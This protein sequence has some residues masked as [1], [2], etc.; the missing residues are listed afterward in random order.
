M[1]QTCDWDGQWKA[2]QRRC[3]HQ[4]SSVDHRLRGVPSALVVPVVHPD[5]PTFWCGNRQIRIA[6]TL[7]DEHFLRELK[8]TRQ[9][10]RITDQHPGPTVVRLMDRDVLGR[11]MKSLCG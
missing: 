10:K 3:H 6:A 1:L 11:E 8:G 9:A 5:L 7:D 2:L 4:E